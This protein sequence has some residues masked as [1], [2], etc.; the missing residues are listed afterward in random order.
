MGMDQMKLDAALELLCQRGCREVNLLIR[1]L[2]SGK[3][4]PEL[5]T[6]DRIE[7]QALLEE[8]RDVMAVYSYRCGV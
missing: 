4:P 3:R 1:D 5:D 8:L 6:L 2:E 7:T